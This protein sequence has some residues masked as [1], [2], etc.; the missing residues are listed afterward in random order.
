MSKVAEDGARLV[1]PFYLRFPIHH[2]FRER[3]A[4]SGTSANAV[5]LPDSGQ[6][7]FLLN[8]DIPEFDWLWERSREDRQS[9]DL[10]ATKGY[11]RAQP[12]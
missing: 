4:A 11:V 7:A 6:A 8:P 12:L 10:I 9:R 5:C 3:A 2:P 1:F